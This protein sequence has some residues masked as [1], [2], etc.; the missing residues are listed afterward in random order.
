MYYTDHL[1]LPKAHDSVLVMLS[2]LCQAVII[3]FMCVCV[4]R[5]VWGC[6]EGLHRWPLQAQS[7]V[8]IPALCEQASSQRASG[9]PPENASPAVSRES[10]DQMAGAI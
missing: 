4:E 7:W 6:G 2:T 3:I 10:N 1:F 5:A 9:S 8:Q